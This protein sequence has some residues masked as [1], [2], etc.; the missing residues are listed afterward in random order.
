MTK[1][2]MIQDLAIAFPVRLLCRLLDVRP[3]SYYYQ[4]RGN[5]DLTV[6]SWIEDVLL[7]F[8]TYGYRR[9]TAQLGREGHPVNHKRIQRV[10]Q[11]NDLIAVVKRRCKTT[12]SRHGFIRYPNRIRDLEVTRPDQVWCAEIV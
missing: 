11:D 6:L 2:Q 12:D 7:R 8:P 5:D 9:V 10:M 4:P 3:S 1:R